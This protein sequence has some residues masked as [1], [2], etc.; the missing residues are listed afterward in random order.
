MSSNWQ[1]LTLGEVVS[2]EIGR[3][4]SR[5]DPAMWDPARQSG[6]VWVSI[7]DLTA[8]EGRVISDSKEYISSMA[9]VAGKP[10]RAGTLMMSFKLSI[11]KLAFAGTDLYTNEAIAALTVKHP[12]R[13]SPDFLFHY[14]SHVDWVSL[15]AG[16]EKVKGATLN[17]AK[18]AVVPV[19]VPPL[20]EQQRIVAK[21]EAL[22]PE[23]EHGLSLVAQTQA[24]SDDVVLSS[25]AEMFQRHGASPSKSYGEVAELSLGKMLDR[26]KATGRHPTPYLRNVNVRWGVFDTSDVMEMDITPSELDRV[27]VRRGDVVVCEG[28]EPGRCAVWREERSMAIQKA[29]H[30]MRPKP[31]MDSD[32]LALNLEYQIKCG[33]AKELFTGTTIKHLTGEKLQV[34][35]LP[36]PPLSE[37][38]E[39]VAHLKAVRDGADALRSVA[40]ARRR[41]LVAMRQSVLAAA[42]RGDL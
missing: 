29:L 20:A 10:V 37:Q 36:V 25:L 18:L 34:M 28:G 14:L 17:K 2:I 16:N 33:T 19:P 9:T 27:S 35:T 4:P 1:W 23:I 24:K 40:D 5:S 6:A 32:Y 7:A 41:T 30:R 39:A 42:F 3:T 13:L 26:K 15:S 22:L 12:E 8:C 31:G 11:G 38:R 21:L